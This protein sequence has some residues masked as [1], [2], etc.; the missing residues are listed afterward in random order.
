MRKLYEL[1]NP[2][3]SIWLTEQAHTNTNFANIC[4]TL[5]IKEKV[6]FTLLSKAINI[7]IEKN[8]SLRTK[9]MLQDGIPKQYVE[10]YT[11]IDIEI[12]EAS[13][14]EEVKKIQEKIVSKNFKLLENYLFKFTIVKLSDGT[15]GFNANLHHVIS[16]AWSM[17]I[18]INQIM[19]NYTKLL[20]NEEIDTENNNS[21][22]EY[23]ELEKEYKESDKYAKNKEFWEES[24]D[25]LPELAK[26]MPHQTKKD[27]LDAKRKPF[28]LDKK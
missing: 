25:V 26:M 19:D 27:S 12:R 15:G 7:F 23:I 14:S 1:T 13:N 18:L 3:K 6:D 24:F 8:D 16:D 17:S 10:K 11:P 20:T 21:Y 9:L 2:Q 4:G 22:F 28:I 5:I